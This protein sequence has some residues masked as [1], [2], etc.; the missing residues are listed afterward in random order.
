MT[1]MHGYHKWTD[2]AVIKLTD[3][4]VIKLTDMAAVVIAVTI[5]ALNHSI[6]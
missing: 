3:I 6:V 4:A 1:D 2:M 5:A